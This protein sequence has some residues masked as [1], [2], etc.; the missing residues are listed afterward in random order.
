MEESMAVGPE[1]ALRLDNLEK[2]QAEKS[3]NEYAQKKGSA[4]LDPTVA[5]TLLE[6]LKQKAVYQEAV[7]QISAV[8]GTPIDDPNKAQ[9]MAQQW[10]NNSL[11]VDTLN[12]HSIEAAQN[13]TNEH[14]KYK[15]ILELF[16]ESAINDTSNAQHYVND[17][18]TNLEFYEAIQNELKRDFP[19]AAHF[20]DHLHKLKQKSAQAADFKQKLQVQESNLKKISGE[21]TDA[22]KNATAC[23][24]Y[25]VQIASAMGDT[26]VTYGELL[27][28]IH[29]Q[30]TNLEE[31]EKLSNVT[32]RETGASHPIT[33]KW[34]LDKSKDDLKRETHAHNY[35]ETITKGAIHMLQHIHFAAYKSTLSESDIK[36]AFIYYEELLTLAKAEGYNNIFALCAYMPPVHNPS[37]DIYEKCLLLQKIDETAFQF[38]IPEKS[39]M[40]KIKDTAETVFETVKEAL[41]EE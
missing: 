25:T 5:N 14:N 17:C 35:Y 40:E 32:V 10:K 36:N 38:D 39:I 31:C 1:E 12:I 19:D 7:A 27:S 26:N 41:S 15:S 3:L 4:A 13:Y 28:H 21:L 23:E 33:L 9:T 29:S 22:Q 24:Y 34:Y 18:K 30:K 16:P 11:I 2:E 8:V 37:R 6:E 20:Q